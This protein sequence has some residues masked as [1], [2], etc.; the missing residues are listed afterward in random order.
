M[1]VA[2]FSSL[3]RSLGYTGTMDFGDEL[4]VLT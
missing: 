3:K 1:T 4:T 2:F